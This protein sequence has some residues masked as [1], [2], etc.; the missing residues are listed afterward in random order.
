MQGP[1]PD[2]HANHTDDLSWRE[3]GLMQAHTQYVSQG[4]SG[5]ANYHKQYSILCNSSKFMLRNMQ[6]VSSVAQK[7]EST[8]APG[9][10]RLLLSYTALLARVARNSIHVVIFFGIL[11]SIAIH[12]NYQW[13]Y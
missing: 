13:D 2:G 10:D 9:T 12:K 4:L 3:L 5:G 7:K 1:N 6:N 11:L 8:A